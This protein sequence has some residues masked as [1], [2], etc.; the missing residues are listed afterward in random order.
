MLVTL[1]ISNVP[2]KIMIDI[3]DTAAELVASEARVLVT[4]V[5][6]HHASS[7]LR[8]SLLTIP[9]KDIKRARQIVMSK[10]ARK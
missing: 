8:V 2:G 9:K 4:S 6:Y 10:R 7:L 1:S 3:M 5:G